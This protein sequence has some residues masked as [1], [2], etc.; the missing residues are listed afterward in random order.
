MRLTAEV[1]TSCTDTVQLKRNTHK[2]RN[3]TVVCYLNRPLVRNIV[4]W[5]EKVLKPSFTVT[6][7]HCFSAACPIWRN[8]EFLSWWD[9]HEEE[10]ECQTHMGYAAGKRSD[11]PQEDPT[12]TSDLNPT[13]MFR[14]A[15]QT[16]EPSNVAELKLEWK[17]EW[18]TAK[19]CK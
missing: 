8:C 17:M 6:V 9:K 19:Y 3:S 10:P 12:L 4:Q 15:L 1:I 16:Q 7:W 11:G 5:C 18:F 14:H 2:S 13:E